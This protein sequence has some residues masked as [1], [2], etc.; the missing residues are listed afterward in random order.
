MR[1]ADRI[2]RFS[3]FSGYRQIPGTSGI[4]CTSETTV[5]SDISGQTGASITTGFFFVSGTSGTS[6][7]SGFSASSVY[8]AA[9]FAAIM[10]LSLVILSEP[11]LAQTG[12]LNVSGGLSITG[13]GYH[14]NGIDGRRAPLAANANG[15]L[16]FNL[17][18]LRSGLN[19]TYTTE[20][21]RL[22]QSVNRLSFDTGWSWGRVSAGDV[23]PDMGKYALQGSTVRG[24]YFEAN[25][26]G[27]FGAVTAGQ[28]RKAVNF[29]E[30]SPFRP[31]S[32]QRLMYAGSLGYGEKRS[33]F[34]SLG[35][36]YARDVA[37]SINRSGA[38]SPAENLVL[39]A[40]GAIQLLERR[41]RLSGQIS[42][43]AL[44]RDFRNLADNEDS[45]FPGFMEV[46]LKPRQG[47]SF[48][49]AGEGEIRYQSPEFSL[50]TRYSR[51][52]PGY[53]SLGLQNIINDQQNLLVQPSF[54][55]FNQRLMVAMNYQY[56]SN[57]LNN[58]LQSTLSR[59][60]IGLNVTGRVSDTFMVTGGYMRMGN[61]NKPG[62][63]FPDP[64]ALQ[65]DFLMQTIMLTPT[66]MINSGGLS[67]V[68]TLSTAWQFSHD[69]SLA[70]RQGL[71]PGR[72]QDVYMAT[73]SYMIRFPSGF[74]LN[75]TGNY[76]FSDAPG[77][78][79]TSY[80]VNTG[81][82]FNLFD[83]KL[84]LNVNTGWSAN[85]S[86]F[87][88]SGTT[89]RRGTQQIMATAGANYRLT[90]KTSIRLQ[91]RAMNNRQTQGSGPG[92]TELQS[93]IAISYQF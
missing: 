80:G 78:S 31:A 74:S 33:D 12:P 88:M 6:G 92:F 77:A 68:I 93:E 58:Q 83:N 34:F 27:F 85:T 57:N 32:F 9:A 20:E 62:S 24:G 54:Q 56:S 39:T 5:T 30:D 51:I 79:N 36:L 1:L 11:V 2:L 75:S 67:Q 3:G 87:A 72:D 60:Q 10:L 90:N 4:L 41:I 55:L 25:H 37:G 38:A 52:Q 49:L 71:R 65:L 26:A 70:V 84:N 81:T 48:N 59:N 7:R 15:N 23:S 50:T 42:S 29:D 43:S 61:L 35:G 21:S 91:S 73:L 82:G 16:Q 17:F 86:E 64:V 28:S 47:S 13:R 19:L 76:V 63:D 14:V 66:M 44:N 46:F 69:R 18:G 40:E 53:E 8:P 22:R 89:A 45:P